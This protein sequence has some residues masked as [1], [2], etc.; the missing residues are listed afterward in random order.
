M[1]LDRLSHGP[2]PGKGSDDAKD[3][4]SGDLASFLLTFA[5]EVRG[6]LHVVAG[7]ADLLKLT[8]PGPDEIASCEAIGDAVGHLRA[9]VDD[10][11]AFAGRRSPTELQ[12]EE[13]ELHDVLSRTIRALTPAAS[14]RGIVLAMD[15]FSI[16][17]KVDGRRLG[18]VF[19]NII[20][21]AIKYNCDRGWVRIHCAER[22]EGR[23][24]VYISD[25]GV[26]V[27]S[28]SMHRVFE[29]FVRLR[30]DIP[31]TGLGLAVSK[32]LVEAMGGEIGLFPRSEGG[33]TVWVELPCF[34]RRTHTT[35]TL[36]V[37][38]AA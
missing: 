33:T 31:G 28:E 12:L 3:F 6:R 10:V 5:H 32:D 20:S 15:E 14:D 8:A 23:V 35:G 2:T 29:P 21:N 34:A 9:L 22:R 13:V 16:A 37:S 7:H 4:R 27:P 17:A 1:E 36:N 19:L 24:R 38:D 30:K 26:G 18:Q 11:V 25:S